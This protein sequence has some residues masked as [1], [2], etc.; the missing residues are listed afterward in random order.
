M[1]SLQRN[2]DVIRNW[3]RFETG[4]LTVYLGIW[5]FFEY[6][7]SSDFHTQSDRICLVFDPIYILGFQGYKTCGLKDLAVDRILDVIGC[8]IDKNSTGEAESFAG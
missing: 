3:E 2:Y 7:R 5:P 8:S 6:I 1:C 4:P